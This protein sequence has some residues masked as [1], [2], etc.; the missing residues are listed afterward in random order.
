MSAD[1]DVDALRAA[2]AASEEARQRL[3]AE[4]REQAAA[5]AAAEKKAQLTALL[6]SRQV[7]AI[8]KLSDENASLLAI[9]N[10]MPALRQR[11]LAE[12]VVDANEE[13]V[14]SGVC[15]SVGE[16]QISD[17]GCGSHE[18]VDALGLCTAWQTSQPSSGQLS[19][20][21]GSSGQGRRARCGHARAP[22]GRISPRLAA[23]HPG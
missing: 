22:A 6:S 19:G 10:G 2:L 21:A 5:V 15:A 3:E 20:G 1:A 8:K 7:E 23:G 12:R 18:G 11:P 4:V 14:R 9:L 17:V 16:P 13:R